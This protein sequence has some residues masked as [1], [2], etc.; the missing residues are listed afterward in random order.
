MQQHARIA[1]TLAAMASRTDD[2]APGHLKTLQVATPNLQ[3]PVFLSRNQCLQQCKQVGL[4]NISASPAPRFT[5]VRVTTRSRQ[6]T[7]PQVLNRMRRRP[8]QQDDN[9][10]AMTDMV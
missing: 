1:A 5:G 10:S 7:A 6:H 3:W 9:L 8:Q 2:L 4:H